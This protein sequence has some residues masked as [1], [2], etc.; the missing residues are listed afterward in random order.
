MSKCRQVNDLYCEIIKIREKYEKKKLNIN[1]QMTGV[2]YT[3]Q[4]HLH[5]QRREFRIQNNAQKTKEN[6]I[7]TILISLPYLTPISLSFCMSTGHTVR[8]FS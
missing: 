6:D 4:N 7:K 5:G 8:E 1:P 2:L 3:E